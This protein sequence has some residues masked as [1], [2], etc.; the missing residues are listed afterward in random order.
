MS[1]KGL[2]LFA[3]ALRGYESGYVLIGGSACDL[4]MSQQGERFRATRDLDIVLL[5]DRGD[6][7]FARALWG[8]VKTGG[9]QPW[10]RRGNGVSFYRFVNPKD[11]SYP[12]MIELFARHPAFDLA[13]EHTE[14]APMPF[15]GEVSSLSAIILDDEYFDF[16]SKGVEVVDG[17]SVLDAQHI[18]P[19]KMRAHID[20]KAR[21]CAG[22]HVNDADLKKHRKDVFRLL[23]LVPGNAFQP[24]TAGIAR[25]CASFIASASEGGFRIDQLGI[26][27]SLDAALTRLSAL[28]GINSG[29]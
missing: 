26:G 15:D 21:K 8:F 7:D 24:L 12:T 5:V 20:L 4:L 10:S 22:E 28:Y 11:D 1:V 27:L 19:L 18:I 25:D 6:T 16:I 3:E 13:D 29:E 17:V 23:T 14:I 9:Y 2:D